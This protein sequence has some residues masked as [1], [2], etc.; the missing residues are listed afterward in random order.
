ML[1]FVSEWVELPWIVIVDTSLDQMIM[2]CCLNSHRTA[3]SVEFISIV[4]LFSI[5]AFAEKKA[6]DSSF[7]PSLFL[8]EIKE[9][10]S[11]ITFLKFIGPKSLTAL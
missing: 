3:F 2:V 10:D 7:F 5:F 9:C 6:S 4:M 1:V 11:F 8:M